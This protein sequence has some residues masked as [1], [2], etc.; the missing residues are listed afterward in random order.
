MIE[1]GD[2]DQITA[3]IPTL[4]ERERQFNQDFLYELQLS[5][6]SVRDATEDL[7]PGRTD[8]QGR[9]LHTIGRRPKRKSLSLADCVVQEK[10]NCPGE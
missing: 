5:I 8:Q 4:A 1:T 10:Q 3:M 6:K 2:F 9:G 7:H